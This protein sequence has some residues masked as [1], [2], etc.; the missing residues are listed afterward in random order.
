MHASIDFLFF[1]QKPSIDIST[2]IFPSLI[3]A[4]QKWQVNKDEITRSWRPRKE[5]NFRVIS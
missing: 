1:S 3:V 4:A 5:R 2:D